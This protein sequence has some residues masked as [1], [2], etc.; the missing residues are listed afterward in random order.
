MNNVSQKDSITKRLVTQ[1]TSCSN[2]MWR[3][4][5]VTTQIVTNAYLVFLLSNVW[6]LCFPELF[7]FGN[8]TPGKGSLS[9]SRDTISLRTKYGKCWVGHSLA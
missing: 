2:A 6:P 7:I 3:S 1:N 9:I 8:I 4:L 5:G